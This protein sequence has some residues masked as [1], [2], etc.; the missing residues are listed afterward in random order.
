MSASCL[1]AFIQNSAR[2]MLNKSASFMPN[3]KKTTCYTTWLLLILWS[4]HKL[5]SFDYL[6]LL[7]VYGHGAGVE[8]M[9]IPGGRMVTKKLD[10]SLSI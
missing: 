2:R 3:M 4:R 7:A 9:E 1:P 6:I 10:P 5:D 8:E